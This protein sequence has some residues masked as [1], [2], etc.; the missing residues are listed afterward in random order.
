[1]SLTLASIKCS[2]TAGQE[3]GDEV[4]APLPVVRDTLYDD[5]MFYAYV[6]FFPTISSFVSLT[7]LDLYDFSYMFG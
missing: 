6:F 1:M 2:R 3:I 7:E 5:A 4:R